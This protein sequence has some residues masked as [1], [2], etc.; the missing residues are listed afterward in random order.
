MSIEKYLVLNKYMLSL[1]GVDD[2]KDLQD[3]F[4]NAPLGV[5][6]NSGKTHFRELLENAFQRIKLSHD[7]L[8]RY[9]DNIQ[10]YLKRINVQRETKITL[11]YFQYLSILFTEIYLDMLKNNKAQFLNDLNEFLKKYK[12]NKK[13]YMVIMQIINI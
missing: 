3:V 5:D 2:F 11:K 7:D 13:S 6:L 4:K 1:L 8:D 10:S 12:E 9:D